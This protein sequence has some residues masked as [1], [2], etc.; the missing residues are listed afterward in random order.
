MDK[1]K[2]S[3]PLADLLDKGS[4]EFLKNLTGK[5]YSKKSKEKEKIIRVKKSISTFQLKVLMEERPKGELY[6]R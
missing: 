5:D 3:Y 2:N 1:T 4:L 6:G